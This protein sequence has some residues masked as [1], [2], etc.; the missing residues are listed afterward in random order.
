MG[1]I[2]LGNMGHFMARN[3][4]KKGH[5]LVVFDIHAQIVNDL[6]KGGATAA[7]S[8][9]EVICFYFLFDIIRFFYEIKNL[10]LRLKLK[11]LSPCCPLILMSKKSIQIAKMEF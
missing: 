11:I 3:L 1:F 4:M 9:S 8:P 5:Q 10:R 6:V 2:G 7:A